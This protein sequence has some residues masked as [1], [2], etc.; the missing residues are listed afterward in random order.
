LAE[1]LNILEL[2]HISYFLGEMYQVIE[3]INEAEMSHV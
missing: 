3:D 1:E 2:D